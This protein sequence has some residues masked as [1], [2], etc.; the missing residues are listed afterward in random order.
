MDVSAVDICNMALDNLGA[1]PPIVSFDDNTDV[2]RTCKRVYP[3]SRNKVLRAHEWNCAIARET[4]AAL[5]DA[6]VS[7]YSYQYQ[8]PIA[9][10]CLRVLNMTNVENAE[11][12]IEGD[13]LLT[14]EEEC[15]IRYIREVTNT[16]EFDPDLIELIALRLAAD[17]AYSITQSK[18]VEAGCEQ[19]YQFNLIRTKGIN[20][21]ESRQ[22]DP[23]TNNSWIDAGRS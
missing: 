18:T 21:N 14:D 7:G 17:I 12:R 6:P 11:Y 15:S 19:K 4:L 23:E 8:L 22:P 2:A 16:T 5:V 1:K 20:N 3:I 9:P 10:L 13:K